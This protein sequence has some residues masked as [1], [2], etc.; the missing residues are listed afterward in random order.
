MEVN[1][2]VRCEARGAD[3]VFTL[4]PK[5]PLELREF[6]GSIDYARCGEANWLYLLHEKITL[7]HLGSLAM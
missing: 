6:R 2:E 3:Q 7:L 4:F 1:A 5:L